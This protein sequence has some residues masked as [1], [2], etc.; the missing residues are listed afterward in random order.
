MV[1][2]EPGIS[3]PAAGTNTPHSIVAQLAVEL[4][5]VGVMSIAASFGEGIGKVMLTIMI[6]FFILWLLTNVNMFQSIVSKV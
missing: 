1:A 2:P 3:G 5:G 6:G 4:I